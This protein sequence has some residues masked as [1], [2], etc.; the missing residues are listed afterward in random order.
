[1]ILCKQVVPRHGLIEWCILTEQRHGDKKRKK[2]NQ[3][4]NI[5]VETKRWSRTVKPKIVQTVSFLERI[6]T[7]K[8]RPVKL[9]T[10][11]FRS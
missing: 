3:T 4:I 10:I 11:V 7:V 9:K 8:L 2:Q 6:M 5:K 1:M